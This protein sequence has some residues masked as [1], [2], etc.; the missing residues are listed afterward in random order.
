MVADNKR[1]YL[2]AI[3]VDEDFELKIR[4]KK[5]RIVSIRDCLKQEEPGAP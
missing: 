1:E 2:V 5:L 4:E 3:V